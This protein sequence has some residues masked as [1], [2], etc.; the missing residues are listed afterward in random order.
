M[1]KL[2][3][4]VLD[5][6]YSRDDPNR[7]DEYRRTGRSTAIALTLIAWTMRNPNVDRMIVDHYPRAEANLML[8][9]MIQDIINTLGLQKFVIR[10]KGNDGLV[11]RYEGIMVP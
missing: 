6:Y 4:K 9:E 2:Y 8:A 5:Q 3:N 7:P 10:K 11:L 1:P